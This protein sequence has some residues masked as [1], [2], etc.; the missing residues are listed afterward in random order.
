[1]TLR[2]DLVVLHFNPPLHLRMP[3]YPPL[4][5]ASTGSSCPASPLFFLP[6]PLFHLFI[7]SLSTN[8]RLRFMIVVVIV[9]R[10]QRVPLACFHEFRALIIPA[11]MISPN[12]F[13]SSPHP[14]ALR[15]SAPP[16]FCAPFFSRS[17]WTESPFMD[18][19]SPPYLQT[20]P[21]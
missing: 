8:L 13:I 2:H 18:A 16:P 4:I 7:P 10:H 20:V 6:R 14:F 9:V 5:L 1:M 15:V 12:V 21:S 19:F 17:W 3:S 11:W